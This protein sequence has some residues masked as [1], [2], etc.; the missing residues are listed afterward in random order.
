MVLSAPM[1]ALALTLALSSSSGSLLAETQTN[2]RHARLIDSPLEFAGSTML[3]ARPIEMMSLPELEAA[4]QDELDNRRSFAAPIILLSVGAAAIITAS[5]L[6]YTFSAP[7]IIAAALLYVAGVGLLIAGTVVLITTIVR[8]AKSSQ[9]VSRLE[10]RI[11][12]LRSSPQPQ[13]AP[14][15]GG[16]EPP[17]PPPPMPQGSFLDLQTPSQQLVLAEF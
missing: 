15:P 11:N 13:Y 16:Y 4:L 10:N 8:N 9:H 3:G 1:I 17:P 6:V 12:Q 5:V 2:M 7:L 14:P